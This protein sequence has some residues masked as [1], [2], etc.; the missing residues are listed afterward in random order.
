MHALGTISGNTYSNTTKIENTYDIVN[1]R[2]KI[3]NNG[4]TW[5]EV[6]SPAPYAGG[7]SGS[8]VSVDSSLGDLYKTTPEQLYGEAGSAKFAK[9]K[10]TRPTGDTT[11]LIWKWRKDALPIPEGLSTFCK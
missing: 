7:G 6:T 10:F 2:Y 1:A 5:V 4:N 9:L 11:S 3:V 8:I